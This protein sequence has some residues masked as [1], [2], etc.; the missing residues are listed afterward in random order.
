MNDVRCGHVAEHNSCAPVEDEIEIVSEK[1]MKR[2]S[3]STQQKD[4]NDDGDHDDDDVVVLDPQTN[5]QKLITALSTSIEPSTVT[6]RSWRMPVDEGQQREQYA[7]QLREDE[8][9]V[10]FKNSV[11]RDQQHT[12]IQP[13]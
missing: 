2:S 11:F 9:C 4:D 1:N 5:S 8:N 13:V 7:G 12:S 3:G 10:A 6:S